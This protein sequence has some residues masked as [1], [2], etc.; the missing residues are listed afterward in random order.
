MSVVINSFRSAKSWRAVSFAIL[1]MI[2][3]ISFILGS[4]IV[5]AQ[6]NSSSSKAYYTNIVVDNGDSLWS[7]AS[8]YMD[9]SRYDSIY[10]YMSELRAL[11]NMTSDK[12]YAGDNLIIV[13]YDNAE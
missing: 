2:I 9:S 6:N 5:K 4:V 11:N 10:D 3:L 1:L 7:I 12:L 13:Y 8:E